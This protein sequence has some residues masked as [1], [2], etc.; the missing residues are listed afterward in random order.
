ML[1]ANES[2]VIEKQLLN[3]RTKHA[4]RSRRR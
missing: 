4:D 3:Q 2:S 1:A